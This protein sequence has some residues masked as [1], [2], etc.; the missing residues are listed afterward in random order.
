VQVVVF[1]LTKVYPQKK[2]LTMTVP[3]ATLV[4]VANIPAKPQ[5][6]R[7]IPRVN[8]AKQ[9][10]IQVWKHPIP[11]IV[12]LPVLLDTITMVW[13]PTKKACAKNV[14]KDKHN[15]VH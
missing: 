4:Q 3:F 5:A 15:P 7:K 10:D 11:P 1:Q 9:V 12:V 14:N 2:T 8:F 13:V 6:W